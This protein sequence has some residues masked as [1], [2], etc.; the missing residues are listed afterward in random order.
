VP[1]ILLGIVVAIVLFILWRRSSVE[2]GAR[3]RDDMVLRE[4][5]PL[6]EKLA[7]GERVSRDEVVDLALRPH[8]RLLLHDVLKHY[9]K[10]DLF[11]EDLRTEPAQA[12]ALLAYW[13]MHPNESQAAPDEVEQLEVIERTPEGEPVRF[14]AM[15]FRHHEPHWA[16]KDGWMLGFAG[17]FFDDDTPYSGNAAAFSTFAKEGEKT[18]AEVVDWYIDMVHKKTG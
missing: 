1:W 9:E 6:G 5:D 18:P 7:G 3:K 16:S 17:P 13:L 15:R 8:L 10:L 4:L 14:Y 2:R 12:E 11:P